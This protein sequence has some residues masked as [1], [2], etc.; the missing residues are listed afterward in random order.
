ML[1]GSQSFVSGGIVALLLATGAGA[2]QSPPVAKR[3][4]MAGVA[5]DSIRGG[6]LRGASVFVSGTALSATT[7]S[8][9]RFRIEGI[10]SGARSLEIQHP[11]LDSLALTLATAPRSFNDGD[12][13]FVMLSVPSAR[14]YAAASCSAEDRTRGP[15]LITGTV[16]DADTEKPSKGA[17]VSIGW[18]DYEIAQKSIKALPQRRVVPVSESGAFRICGLPEDL[19][20][21]VVASRGNDSTAAVELDLKSLVGTVALKLPPARAPVAIVL[22]SVSASTTP[23]PAPGAAFISG[24]VLDVNGKPAR[25]A[26]VAI[27]ADDAVATT[28]ADGTFSL[29]GL[30]PGTRRLT[31]RKIGFEPVEKAVEV[32]PDGTPDMK[33]TLGKSVEVLKSIVVRAKVDFGLQR[34]GFTQR[35]QGPRPGVFFAPRDIELRN[36]PRLGDLLRTVPMMRRPGCVRYFIDGFLQAPGDPDEYLSGAEIGAVEVYSS[37]F[38][39]VEF[40]AYTPT[41]GRCSA[42]VVWTKWKIDKR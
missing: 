5:V 18:T 6:F 29:T 23:A 21:A 3:A 19:V 25:G 22:D 13:S 36:G 24:S 30:R 28:R 17:S 41:G 39:P 42:V 35:K 8:A 26:R 38:G 4:I 31:V 32:R 12:S 14:T 9:G 10:P 34:V 11:L 7:D 40:M 1:P 16:H 27:D 20:A 33:L 2:Q 15:A 37:N